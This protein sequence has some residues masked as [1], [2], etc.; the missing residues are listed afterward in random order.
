MRERK[1]NR[2]VAV[3]GVEETTEQ[4]KGGRMK[5]RGKTRGPEQE[6]GKEGTLKK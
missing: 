3:W 1:A 5:G 2:G 4:Q 6:Q